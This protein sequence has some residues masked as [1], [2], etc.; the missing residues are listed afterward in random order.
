MTAIRTSQ[1]FRLLLW[2]EWLL[3]GAAVFMELLL[4]FQ[5]SMVLIFRLLSIGIFAAI[6]RW[7]PKHGTLGTRWLYTAG[8]CALIL[9]AIVG[10]S[11]SARSVLVLC[12]ILM[13][14][15]CLLLNRSGQLAILG[16]ALTT[17]TTVILIKPIVR[18]RMMSTIWDWRL[19]N[20]LMSDLALIFALLLINALLAERHI[21]EQLERAQAE[22]ATAHIQLRD[23]ALRIEDR[24]TLQ[25]RNRIA[26]EIHD[27]LGHTLTAQ[28]IQI[29]NTLLFWETDRD[30]AIA[31]LR[32][33]K[34]LG[35]EAML[36]IRRSISV[37]RSNPLQG[38]PLKVA[39]QKLLADFEHNT[40]IIPAAQIDIPTTLP[41][42]IDTT[43]YRI[44]QESLTNI[45]KHAKAQSI[46]LELKQYSDRIQMSIAD[47]GRGFNPQQ[48]TTGF[49]LRGMQ[50]RAVAL[51]GKFHIESQPGDGCCISIS[52]PQL[53][54]LR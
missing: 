45:H 13:M 17:Y 35:A 37:L 18:E 1:P 23:Y 54:Q 50:E 20:I 5:F 33:A 36:E 46:R 29:N 19:S 51:G 52:L 30:R 32:Q 47:N 44:L 11:L 41:L 39:V 43:L 28:T 25:E 7:L 22:L 38:K 3:L 49:G 12:L 40:G 48:N 2:L 8:E 34:Q 42:E 16:F 9:I 6:G 21:R 53:Q 26:R 4:P 27:G 15:T 14:R 24:A 10:F 31:F